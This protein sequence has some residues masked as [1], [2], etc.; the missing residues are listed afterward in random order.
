MTHSGTLTGAMNGY[1]YQADAVSDRP[2]WHNT[3]K[4]V[5]A[6]A[7]ARIPCE[8]AHIMQLARAIPT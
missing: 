1:T 8:D 6:H 2:A 5:S 4:T 7:D 3:S